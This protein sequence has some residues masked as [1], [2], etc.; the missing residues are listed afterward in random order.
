M[1]KI[2]LKIC[3]FLGTILLL[4]PAMASAQYYLWEIGN[5]DAQYDLQKDSSIIVSES[6]EAKFNSDNP[7]HGIIRYIPIKYRNSLQQNLDLR[8]SLISITDQNGNPLTYEQTWNGDFVDLKIGDAD[9]ELTTPQTYLIKYKLERG[10]NSFDDHDELYWNVTGNGWDTSIESATATVILPEKLSSNNLKATCFTGEEFSTDSDCTVDI[11]T[12]GRIEVKT[13]TLLYSYAGLT[14]VVGFPKGTI[15]YPSQTTL[16]LWFLQ[17]NWGYSLPLITLALMTLYWYYNGRDPQANRST[18]MPHYEPPRG[19]L[20]AEAGTLIDNTVNI[21]DITSTII[22]LA[23]RGYLIIHENKSKGLLWEHINYQFEKTNPPKGALPLVNYEHKVYDAIFKGDVTKV[24]L[25]T[26][27]NNFYSHIPAIESDIYNK[28]VK[29][30]YYSKNPR[31]SRENFVGMGC[32]IGFAIIFI[33]GF[34]VEFLGL[35]FLFGSILSC[36][37]IFLFAFIMPQRT[38]EGMNVYYEVLGLEEFI[39]TA[40]KDRMKFYEQQ[41]IFEKLLPYAISFQLTDKWA[42]ACKDLFKTAPNWYTSSDPNFNNFNTV[43]FLNS[44]NHFS[45]HLSTNMTS[46][47]R[48]SGSSAA[49]GSSGFGGGGF[50]GGG[51]GG[52]GGSSW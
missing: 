36:L 47:P 38:K 43:Y 13:N 10:I 52:G 7:K 12:D 45:N 25:E 44:F 48:S 33:G 35:S 21:H 20:P 18:I 17:D 27:K 24:Q 28:L 29:D 2:F 42:T 30:G 40:E 15:D 49:G 16:L 51:F 34:L 41:N 9:I 1:N 11:T 32:G 14:I 50:S 26:L 22:S 4:F 6:I 23:V 39:K 46:S 19:I 31:S 8:F 5:F 37:V 3:L